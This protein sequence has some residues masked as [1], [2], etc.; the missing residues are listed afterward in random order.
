MWELIF[1]F[2]FSSPSS[3]FLK[4]YT[5]FDVYHAGCHSAKPAYGPESNYSTP[6][7]L[8]QSQ[9]LQK[10]V[11]NGKLYSVVI[12]NALHDNASQTVYVV[13]MW[14]SP[15]EQGYAQGQLLGPV[16][17]SFIERT[18][19]YL[20][21]Q[22]ELVLHH[23]PAW[24]ARYIADLGLDA[25]LD[26]TEFLTR[27]ETPASYYALMRGLAES[28]GVSYRTLIRVHMLAG[29]T[30][31]K[32][33][34]V[35]AWGAALDP[36]NGGKLLQLRA[37]DWNMDGPF[38]DY[39]AIQVF[40][41]QGSDP[42][43]RTF[44]TVGFPG[45]IGALT[46]INDARVAISEIGVSYPDPSFG[47]E[48]RI[49]VPFI[50]MLREILE[51]DTSLQAAIERMQKKRRTCDLILGVGDGKEGIARAFQYSY[52][53]LNVIDDKHFIPVNNTWHAPIADAVYFGMD[54]LCPTFNKVL[55]DQLRKY[56]G[57]IT[58]LIAR[59]NISAVEMSGDNHL[60]WYDLTNGI[61]WAAFAAPN[62]VG[63]PVEAYWRQYVEIDT[64]SV[65]TEPQ[66]K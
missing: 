66:P 47:S 28:S 37:L 10:S 57:Q 60:A 29:L 22:V 35:G 40:H 43:A 65:F 54:W 45:F 34:I 64:N 56:Y 11:K 32:C 36:N 6:V 4:E 3:K 49:G 23:V 8:S 7:V 41:A 46:G 9:Q 14:G 55:G 5:S 20:E 52:S 30:Q 44:L 27:A 50:F 62:G 39:A 16:V 21:Q 12:P 17:K 31:G 42:K 48:S 1:F 38:R 51:Y 25:A 59:Q 63:G 26:L 24:L 19:A 53:V 61:V 18:W 2:F 15:Y 33:S 13:H 58:P